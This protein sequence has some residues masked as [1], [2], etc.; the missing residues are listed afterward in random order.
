VS[1]VYSTKFDQSL[2]C[3]EVF[4]TYADH[5]TAVDFHILQGERDFAKIVEA[6]GDLN[7]N[8]SRPCRCC[9][10]QSEFFNGCPMGSFVLAA[11]DEKTGN[12]ATLDVKPSFGLTD[13]EI[14]TMLQDAWSHA[15][16]DFKP[17][18]WRR[19]WKSS[20]RFIAGDRKDS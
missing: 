3:I 16:S 13:Q 8:S 18:N 11:L 9:E 19:A 10:D 15:E 5:Q 14:E 6:L 4:T 20:A 1:R 17:R 2:S 7:E 12:R